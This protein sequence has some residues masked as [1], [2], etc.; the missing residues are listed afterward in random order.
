MEI[1]YSNENNGET[2]IKLKIDK[3]HYTIHGYS[4]A[5]LKTCILV[6]EFNV[7][8]DMGYANDK[9]FSYDNKLISHGHIDHIGSLHYDHPSRKLFNIN[10]PRLYIMPEQCIKPFKM[11]ISTISELNCGK[12]G[13]NIK[14]FDN[15]ILTDILPS[16]YFINNY[17]DLIGRTIYK[18]E[19]VIRTFL[20]DHK[21]KSYGY[22]IYRKTNRLKKEY[23][24]LNQEEIIRLKESKII[25]TEEYYKPLIG[26][27]GDT[28]INGLNEELFNVPLLLMEC[29][30][31]SDDDIQYTKNGKHIHFNDIIEN[32][33]K[34][35]NNKIILFHF[36]QQ[37]R[38]L[39]DILKYTDKASEDL[40]DKIIYFF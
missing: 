23:S 15:L 5:G 33:D 12:S 34:F 38:E 13:E 10:K 24:L 40:K 14:V 31:F 35:K 17:C 9:A 20:M 37:Y 18:S 32:K 19:Y 26:Y 1:K 3:Q 2:F 29:T 22:I 16:E 4:R 21:I 36:S 25:I 27:T 11:M 7:V 8:F 28:T 6:D 30:G 39:T